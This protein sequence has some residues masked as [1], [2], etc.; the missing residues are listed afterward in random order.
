MT[1]RLR[2]ITLTNF[3][4]STLNGTYQAI[5]GTGT[6]KPLISFKFYNSSTSLVI[7]SYDGVNDHDFVPPGSSFIFDAQTN[8]EPD[9]SSEG[10]KLL[11]EGTVVYAKTSSNTSRLLMAGYY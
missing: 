2:N 1:N 8:A 9:A 6:A 11:P 4:A 7:I 3:D 10:L 5:N